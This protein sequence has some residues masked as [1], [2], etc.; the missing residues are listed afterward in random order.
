MGTIALLNYLWL[1]T[2][3]KSADAQKCSF[4][5]SPSVS[6]EVMDLFLELSSAEDSNESPRCSLDRNIAG[7]L[8]LLDS[9]D[10]DR[11]PDTQPIISQILEGTWTETR[12]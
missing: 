7:I 6:V 3:L 12:S 4:Q 1:V 2:L 10:D 5:K 11:V 8:D 9:D